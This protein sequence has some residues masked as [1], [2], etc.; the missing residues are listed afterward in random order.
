MADRHLADHVGSFRPGLRIRVRRTHP[1]PGLRPVL[2]GRPRRP[3]GLARLERTVRP[4]QLDKTD[5]RPRRQ[6]LLRRAKA[7]VSTRFRIAALVPDEVW[8]RLLRRAWAVLP[9]P[10]HRW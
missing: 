4:R 7:D 9:P 2:L 3:A 5:A 8:H 10:W 1:R 6:R